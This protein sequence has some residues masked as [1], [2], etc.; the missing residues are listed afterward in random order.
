ML[1][2]GQSISRP[3]EAYHLT[4]ISSVSRD[5]RSAGLDRLW[6]CPA[7]QDGHQ[8]CMQCACPVAKDF[9]FCFVFWISPV[10]AG[11]LLL[12]PSTTL[13][14]PVLCQSE[15]SCAAAI[16]SLITEAHKCYLGGET[17]IGAY[18][19]QCRPGIGQDLVRRVLRALVN[20][21]AEMPEGSAS[22]GKPAEPHVLCLSKSLSCAGFSKEVKA[23]HVC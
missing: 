16:A 19:M 14:S 3:K 20:A 2:L 10:A 1:V 7:L 9:D 18:A 11:C 21:A 15:V 6:D 5:P 23:P 17:A 22:A 13:S 12:K 4:G 8:L